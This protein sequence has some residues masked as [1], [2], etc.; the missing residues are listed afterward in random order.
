MPW[1][2]ERAILALGHIWSLPTEKVQQHVGRN[3]QCLLA[4]HGD[5]R[6]PIERPRCQ[7]LI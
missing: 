7:K 4:Q 6:Y 1:Q 3:L 2:T 5:R